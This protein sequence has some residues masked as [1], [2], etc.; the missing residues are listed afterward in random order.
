LFEFLAFD[1]VDGARSGSDTRSRWDVLEA[2]TPHT[3]AMMPSAK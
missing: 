1:P 3:T 2:G